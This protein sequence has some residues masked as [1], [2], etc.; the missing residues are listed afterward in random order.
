[1]LGQI[2]VTR[3]RLNATDIIDQ[4]RRGCVTE[5]E[6]ATLEQRTKRDVE[7]KILAVNDGTRGNEFVGIQQIQERR[8]NTF[9]TE[10]RVV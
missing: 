5:L 2:S 6:S 4:T 9:G 3:N 10:R 7:A 1:M 8:R